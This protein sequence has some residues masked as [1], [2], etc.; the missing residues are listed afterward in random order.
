MEIELEKMS[1]IKEEPEINAFNS[2]DYEDN[3]K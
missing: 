2:I 1:E 3:G